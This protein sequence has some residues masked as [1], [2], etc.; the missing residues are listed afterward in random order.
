[1]MVEA[2]SAR[3]FAE[4]TCAPM[5]NHQASW[6][7]ERAIGADLA[8]SFTAQR[9]HLYL[10]GTTEKDPQKLIDTLASR[11]PITL[12]ESGKNAVSAHVAVVGKNLAQFSA[13]PD[14][15][16]VFGVVENDAAHA[17]SAPG[18][19]VFVS[20][21]LLRKMTNEAQLA[22]VLA[23]EISHVVRKD[24]LKIWVEASYRQCVAANYAAYLIEHGQP[25]NPM[26]EEMARYAKK[27]QPRMD[28]STSDDA[29]VRFIMNT[30]MML[31]QQG[32]DKESEFDADKAALELISF[33][34][35]DAL[36]YE[37]FLIDFA[38][39]NHPVSVERA[40]RLEQYRKGELSDFVHGTAKPDLTKLFAPL[41]PKPG[42]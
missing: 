14:L 36:E 33:A 32:H 18:G 28:L 11:Q 10:E 21:G 41:A 8:V 40:S 12:P 39:V 16:W 3:A 22:G 31:L 4:V 27:F 25:S 5:L 15:P 9:G 1:M 19:Y 7:E 34:G 23:H 26:T 37:K 30:T 38:Q 17:F 42:P 24:M 6:N 2:Q 35:Y 13:R 20:T 29:F